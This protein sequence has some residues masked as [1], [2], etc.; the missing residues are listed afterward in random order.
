MELICF[1]I[2]ILLTQL[3]LVKLPVIERLSFVQTILIG[4]LLIF[5]ASILYAFVHSIFILII[6]ISVFGTILMNKTGILMNRY[7]KK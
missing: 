5:A 6:A 4:I 3:L 2:T 1:I 7:R